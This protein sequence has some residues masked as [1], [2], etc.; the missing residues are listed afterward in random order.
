KLFSFQRND[1]V[2]GS[3]GAEVKPKLVALALARSR[4]LSESDESAALYTTAVDDDWGK[5]PSTRS[6]SSVAVSVVTLALG[7]RGVSICPKV[8]VGASWNRCELGSTAT[9]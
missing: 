9:S 4:A 5:L 3:C 1:E 6:N 2:V 7:K 8:R